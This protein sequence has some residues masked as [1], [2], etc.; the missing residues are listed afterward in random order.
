MRTRACDAVLLSRQACLDA[1][2]FHALTDES[3]LLSKR[4]VIRS[5]AIPVT[6]PPAAA[7]EMSVAID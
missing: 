4:A 1:H 5:R 3:P 6:Q 2:D 7:E